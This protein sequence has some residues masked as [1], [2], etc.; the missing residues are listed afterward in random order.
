[1]EPDIRGLFTVHH[2]QLNI[3][4]I[5]DESDA[6]AQ[7]SQL[8][9]GAGYACQCAHSAVDAAEVIRH[10]TPDL[11]ISDINLAGY[12]GLTICEQLKHD[13]GLGH[14]P[15]MFLSA[16]QVPD[17]IRRSHALGGTYHLRKPYDQTVLLQL[18]AKAMPVP[19]LTGA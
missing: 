13:A 1:L 19:H 10:F 16:G 6:L 8:L 2:A 17:I 7:I 15:V 14:V 12:N 5:D 3:L 9:E 18:V 4:A 11:I